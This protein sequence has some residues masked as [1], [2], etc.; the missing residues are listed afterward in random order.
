[1]LWKYLRV[2]VKNI[3]GVSKPKYWAENILY[4]ESKFDVTYFR[5]LDGKLTSPLINIKNG[6]FLKQSS[7]KISTMRK[8]A[9]PQFK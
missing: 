9:A 1:M 5:Y 2:V 4:Y 7:P 3:H 8:V 6:Q